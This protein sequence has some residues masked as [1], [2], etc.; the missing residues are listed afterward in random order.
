[1]SLDGKF[2]GLPQDTGPL[3]YY[4]NKAAFEELGLKVP[5]TASEFIDTAKKAAEKGK[6]IAT[7]Q[8]DRPAPSSRRSPQPLVTSGSASTARRGRYP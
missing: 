2:F 3:V 6:Y 7:F 5:T 1:M 4:Y 8:T